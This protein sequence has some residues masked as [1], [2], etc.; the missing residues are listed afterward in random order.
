MDNL[1]GDCPPVKKKNELIKL[2]E[3][4]SLCLNCTIGVFI[5]ASEVHYLSMQCFRKTLICVDV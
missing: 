3:E 5:M 2:N 1:V 4:V